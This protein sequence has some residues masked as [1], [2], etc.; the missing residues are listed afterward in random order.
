MRQHAG[1]YVA[2]FQKGLSITGD[3][4]LPAIG[5]RHGMKRSFTEILV[6][7]K[8]YVIIL[9]DKWILIVPITQDEP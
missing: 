6:F 7:Y 9:I 5:E 3:H 2:V 4:I 1:R 8:V